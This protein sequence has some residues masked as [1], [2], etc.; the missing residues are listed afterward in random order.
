[1]NQSPILF[2]VLQKRI[3]E[4][5]SEIE[6]LRNLLSLHGIAENEELRIQET[7]YSPLITAEHARLL[8]SYF[9]GRKDVFSLRNI[10]KEGKGVYYP[11]CEHFWEQGNFMSLR[12]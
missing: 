9:K 12:N 1:M 7:L 8:Y 4:L 3:L 6:R 11:V 2:S 10:N 5:E